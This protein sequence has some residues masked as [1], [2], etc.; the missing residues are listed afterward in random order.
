M[1]SGLCEARLVVLVLHGRVAGLGYC[2]RV[3]EVGAARGQEVSEDEGKQRH[4]DDDKQQRRLVSDF[5]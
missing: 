2:A 4:D 1:L 3:A 5:L